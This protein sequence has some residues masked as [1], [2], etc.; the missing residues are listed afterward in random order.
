MATPNDRRAVAGVPP[1][2]GFTWLGLVGFGLLVALLAVA[3]VQT[4]Q[5]ALLSKAVQSGDDSTVLSVHQVETEH[6]RLREQWLRAAD[7]REPLDVATLKLRYDIWVSQV[8]LLRADRPQRLIRSD[9]GFKHTLDEVETFIAR[10]DH[11]LGATP[12]A[13]ATREF[14]QSLVP[15]LQ[16]LGAPLHGLSLGAAHRLSVQLE[17]RT[18]A[19]RQQNLLGLGLTVFLSVLTLAF[20]I[21]ALRQVQRSRER[22]VALEELATSLRQARQDAEAASESDV[23]LRYALE[24]FVGHI[25]DGTKAEADWRAGYESAVWAIKTAEAMAKNGRVEFGADLWTV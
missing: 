12:R 16:A 7:E 18:A 14:V 2:T 10:A 23:P 11:A 4:R 19:V 3:L 5:F 21:I 13:E 24:R 6:L 22:R 9:D 17:E 1:R 20:A 8:E 25:N 15:A